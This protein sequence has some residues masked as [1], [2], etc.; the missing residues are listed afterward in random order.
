MRTE[1]TTRAHATNWITVRRPP[2]MRSRNGPINGAIS[3]N[4]AKLTTRNSKTCSRPSSGLID[5]NFESARATTIAASPAIMA[6]WVMLRRRNFDSPA[7]ESDRLPI[8]NDCATPS[9]LGVR[10]RNVPRSARH[11]SFG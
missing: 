2:A 10:R 7:R 5:R 6:A 1:S 4:G 11:S 9:M 8:D 3:R